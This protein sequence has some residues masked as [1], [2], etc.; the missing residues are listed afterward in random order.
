MWKTLGS[1]SSTTKKKK[2]ERKTDSWFQL[3]NLFYFAMCQRKLFCFILLK[4][5]PE[6]RV[7]NPRP[8]LL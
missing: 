4:K 8:N 2:K 5:E 6:I 7:L 3:D 1:I